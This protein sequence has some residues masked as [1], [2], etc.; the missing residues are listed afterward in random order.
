MTNPMNR[1]DFIT[2]LDR[3]G[4]S[5]DESRLAEVNYYWNL[6]QDSRRQARKHSMLAEV[7]IIDFIKWMK[8]Q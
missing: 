2:A 4:I 3:N 6:W 7:G 1:N 8:K 5:L